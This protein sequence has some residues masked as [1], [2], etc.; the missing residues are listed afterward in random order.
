M[1]LPVFEKG[2]MYKIKDKKTKK[3]TSGEFVHE[4]N[5]AAVVFA[6]YF[7]VNGEEKVFDSDHF[8]FSAIKTPKPKILTTTRKTK[9][10]I[11]NKSKTP[12]RRSSRI[13]S[14]KPTTQ[15]KRK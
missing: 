10:P 8:T 4:A 9:T 3:V 7:I 14:Q 15:K 6:G 11:Q 13:A 12:P 1:D 2:K 5:N